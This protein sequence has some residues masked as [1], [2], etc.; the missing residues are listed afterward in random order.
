ME[1]AVKRAN[2]KLQVTIVYCWVAVDNIDVPKK[3]NTTII[4]WTPIFEW[5]VVRCGSKDQNQKDIFIWKDW[6][7]C[8]NMRTI[9]SSMFNMIGG[10]MWPLNEQENRLSPENYEAK[11]MG[12]I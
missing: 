4:I 5:C 1:V 6:T 3:S 8:H 10:P 7:T 12:T 2:L 9:L 11:A